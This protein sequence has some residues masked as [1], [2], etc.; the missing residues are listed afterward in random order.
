MRSSWLRSAKLTVT[1]RLNELARGF[2]PSEGQSP[3]GQQINITAF[4]F[5]AFVLH[6]KLSELDYGEYMRYCVDLEYREQV[7]EGWREQWKRELGRDSQ[8]ERRVG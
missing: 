3:R 2:A 8:P 6:D 5:W 1:K 7:L 4:D